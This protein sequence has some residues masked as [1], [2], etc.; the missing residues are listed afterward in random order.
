MVQCL[1]YAESVD[2]NDASNLLLILAF[3]GLILAACA[4][5]FVPIALALSRRRRQARG[6]LQVSIVWG[7]LAAAT[8]G[9][10]VLARFNWA[11]EQALRLQTGYVD[12]GDQ[13]AAPAQ[14]IALY[15]V[16][17]IGYVALLAWAIAP[18]RAND[19]QHP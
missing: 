13:S 19:P 6:I 2:P 12:P 11:R 5:A 14:P 16:V 4:S 9:Y 7:L 3:A 17:G 10:V 8:T 18:H 1:A 15:S